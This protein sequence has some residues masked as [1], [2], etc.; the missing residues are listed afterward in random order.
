M[1]KKNIVK[2]TKDKPAKKNTKVKIK[3]EDIDNDITDDIEDIDILKCDDDFECE[4]DCD[5]FKDELNDDFDEN[6]DH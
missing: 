5:D 4:C 6:E 1:V 3:D 2:K